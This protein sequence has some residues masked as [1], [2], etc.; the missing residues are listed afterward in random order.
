MVGLLTTVCEM[1]LMICKKCFQI[2]TGVIEVEINCN[3]MQVAILSFAKSA[4]RFLLAYL[5][6]CEVHLVINKTVCENSAT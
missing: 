6:V 3:T 1:R 4:V 5:L 2:S